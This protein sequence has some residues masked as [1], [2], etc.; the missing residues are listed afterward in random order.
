[1]IVIKDSKFKCND[2]KIDEADLNKQ[3]DEQMGA[4][5]ERVVRVK[6]ILKKGNEEPN[7]N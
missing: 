1:M 5:L 2:L 6:S 4:E 3:V 7:V